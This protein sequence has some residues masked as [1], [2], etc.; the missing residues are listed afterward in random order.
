MNQMI[1]NLSRFV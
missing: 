1:L